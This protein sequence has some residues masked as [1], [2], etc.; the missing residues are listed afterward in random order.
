MKQNRS[1]LMLSSA[2]LPIVLGLAVGVPAALTGAMVDAGTA[3]ASCN[4][5]SAKNPC[6][7]ACN[8]CAA[9]NPCGAACNPCAATNPC[10]AS[11]ACNPCSAKNPCAA[12]D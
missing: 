6:G 7:A 8:P 4:P 9:N 12:N 1:K 11:N 10:G 5:C 2:V 3:Y